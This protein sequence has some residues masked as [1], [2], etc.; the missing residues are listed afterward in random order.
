MYM[1][2]QEKLIINSNA[3]AHRERFVLDGFESC[4]S[5]FILLKPPSLMLWR[6]IRLG[7]VKIV[8]FRVGARAK[9]EK[10]G[11]GRE[12]TTLSLLSP[13][14]RSFWLIPF[15]PLFLHGTFAGKTF[16]HPKKTPALQ[17]ISSADVKLL[18]R[19]LIFSVQWMYD[20][21]IFVYTWLSANKLSTLDVRKMCLSLLRQSGRY[22]R[23]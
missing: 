20:L 13:L 15:S 14:P 2:D 1:L 7:R 8:T 22:H 4:L 16:A 21:S 10:G 11:G 12:K 17:A 23:L 18:S 5:M 19:C 6:R 3:K 9:E